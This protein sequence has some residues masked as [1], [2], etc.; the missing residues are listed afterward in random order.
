LIIRGNDG[1]LVVDHHAHGAFVLALRPEIGLAAARHFGFAA[2]I[3][4]RAESGIDR[5]ADVAGETFFHGHVMAG[6][7][8][9]TD[10]RY[11]R[12]VLHS[13]SPASGGSKPPMSSRDCLLRRLITSEANAR[14]RQTWRSPAR[15]AGL[16]A[17]GDISDVLGR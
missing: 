12:D 7:E 11:Q 10:D 13:K 9:Q 3:S 15:R 14:G 4:E 2:R 17:A 8:R 6:G 16:L 5:L 1:F